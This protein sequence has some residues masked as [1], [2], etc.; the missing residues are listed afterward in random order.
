MTLALRNDLPTG[1]LHKL[2][3]EDVAPQLSSDVSKEFTGYAAGMRAIAV[4]R[5]KSRKEADEIMLE[6]APV[7]LLFLKQVSGTDTPP[8]PVQFCFT[9]RTQLCA[10]SS[11]Q[12]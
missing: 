11:S 6:S 9:R 4:A 3:V 12:T 8:S 1:L 2:V 10:R 5:P 7:R